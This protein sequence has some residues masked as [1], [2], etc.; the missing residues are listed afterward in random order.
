MS[1]FPGCPHCTQ[2][3]DGTGTIAPCGPTRAGRSPHWHVSHDS[4]YF[5]YSAHIGLYDENRAYLDKWEINNE[6]PVPW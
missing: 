6:I 3:W 2:N 4:L 5:K 1:W